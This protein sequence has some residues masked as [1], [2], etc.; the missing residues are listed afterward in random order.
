MSFCFCPLRSGSSGNSLYV[1][2]GHTRI[3]VDA[4]LSGK[5]VEQALC[6]LAVSPGTLQAILITHEH[7]DHIKGAGILSRR[8]D[9]PVY[10]TEGTWIAMESKPGM[11]G[12][13]L[14]N[15]RVFASDEDFYIGDLAVSPFSIPHDA[16]DPVGFALLHTGRKLCVATD[17]GHIAAGWMKALSG[18][19]LLLM[20]SNYDPDMLRDHHWYSSMLK[21]RIQGNR[22]HLS[23]GDCGVALSRLVKMGLCHVILG[24]LSA[25][26][27][28]PELARSTVCDALASEGIQPGV[29]VQVDIAL[30][31]CMGRL[32]TIG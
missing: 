21:K 14:R 27:N 15:R 1:Q 24:H 8:Y 10:A 6:D 18:A 23:N 30:R 9:L 20:E 28:T 31:D 7:S 16:A 2:A 26:T 25:E 4:G 3:L 29:D 5:T 13:A 22:G 11:D 17:L 19:D 12:I 32:Y